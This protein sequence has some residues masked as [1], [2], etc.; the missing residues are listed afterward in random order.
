[1]LDQVCLR[2]HEFAR[3]SGADTVGTVHILVSVLSSYG[4]DVDRELYR[5]G[6]SRDELFGRL[7][8]DEALRATG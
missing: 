5:R 7:P 2:A 3:A 4:V 8:R 1:T 6:T